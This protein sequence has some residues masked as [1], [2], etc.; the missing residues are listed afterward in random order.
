MLGLY[1]SFSYRVRYALYKIPVLGVLVSR[2]IG[3]ATNVLTGCYISP[4]AK[5]GGGL[6]LPHPIGVVVGDKVV[7][8]RRARIYQ[9]V[10]LGSRATGDNAY[11]VLSDF[12]TVFPNS[13]IVGSIKLGSSVTVGAGSIVLHS[14]P[15]GAVL[16]GN[17]SRQVKNRG[18]DLEVG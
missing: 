10:T 13:V 16:V 5:I 2:I 3:L 14:A 18:A 8:G 11:P 4:K 15:D 12:V 6:Y 17:P 9:G 7:I 1:V